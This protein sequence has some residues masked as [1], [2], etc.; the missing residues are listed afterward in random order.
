MKCGINTGR[1]QILGCTTTLS[2]I[3]VF[4]VDTYGAMI[5]FVCPDWP[6]R[7]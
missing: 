1:K 4:L 7:I 2:H 6:E 3:L 5:S